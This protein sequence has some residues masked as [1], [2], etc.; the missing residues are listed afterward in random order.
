MPAAWQAQN[1]AP[2]QI[3]VVPVSSLRTRQK[4]GLCFFAA[5]AITQSLKDEDDRW[6]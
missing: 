2:E 5:E 4:I 1:V 6:R 3:F